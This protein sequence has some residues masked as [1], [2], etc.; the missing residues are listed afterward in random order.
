MVVEKRASGWVGGGMCNRE[1]TYT[2][3]TGDNYM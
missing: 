1:H 3:Y 2:L